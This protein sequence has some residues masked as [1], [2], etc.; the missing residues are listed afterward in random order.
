MIGYMLIALGNIG[1]LLV[2]IVEHL[3]IAIENRDILR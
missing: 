1:N 2:S 3:Y